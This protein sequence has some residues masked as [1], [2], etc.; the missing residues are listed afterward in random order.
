[1]EYNILIVDDLENNRIYLKTL[2]EAKGHRVTEAENGKEALQ[3]F[4]SNPFDIVMTD[5]HMPE[6]D[7]LS[8]L[9]LIKI[10]KPKVPVIIISA[11]GESKTIIDALRFG[12]CDFIIKPYEENDVDNSLQRIS[13]FY[14]SKTT[15][16]SWEKNLINESADYIF[17][18]NPNQINGLAQ[19]LCRSLIKLNLTSEVQSL[20][21]SLIEAISNAIYHGNLEIPPDLKKTKSTRSFETFRKIVQARM[22]EA[23]FDN[24]KIAIAYKLDEEKVIYVIKDEGPGFDYK[25][26]PSP[27]NPENFLKP[28]GRGLFM[29][30]AFCEE[31]S[32]NESGNEITLVKYLQRNINSNQTSH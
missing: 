32:W 22:N 16:H 12:A 21:V 30:R 23:P 9:R 20:Q 3:C 28:N 24:R 14:K 11:Y 5:L 29:I 18:N 7:G 10:N 13:R 31:V 27:T 1:M 25:S 15:D 17:E 26:L 2:L 8:L 19:F 4:Q 6:M